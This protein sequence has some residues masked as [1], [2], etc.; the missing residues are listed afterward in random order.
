MTPPVSRARLDDTND[1]RLVVMGDGQRAVMEWAKNHLRCHVGELHPAR[2]AMRQYILR[3]AQAAE[4]GVA[5]YEA[6]PADL[7]GPHGAIRVAI[8]N[9]YYD[10]RNA[11]E[12]M[13]MAADNAAQAVWDALLAEGREIFQCS[14]CHDTYEDA[15]QPG[16]HS[17]GFAC[18]GPP[19]GN[20]HPEIS[21]TR[22]LV[23]P[24]A[25]PSA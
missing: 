20:S 1:T 12:T 6:A 13:E 5:A 4:D 16:T 8:T 19:G 18:V 25:E 2:E 3:L 9:A 14:A 23:L 7:S 22:L 11:G 15:L 10:A 24:L 17:A 21:M